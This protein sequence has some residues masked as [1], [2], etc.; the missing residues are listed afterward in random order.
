MDTAQKKVNVFTAEV[1][2]FTI[3]VVYTYILY[4]ANL[5]D[6]LPNLRLRIAWGNQ[7]DIGKVR[8]PKRLIV[9]GYVKL[10]GYTNSI[11]WHSRGEF[12]RCLV[13]TI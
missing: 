13:G 6:T 12:R 10:F 5:T 7:L 8:P 11:L 3:D 9:C 1:H 2:P 4:E